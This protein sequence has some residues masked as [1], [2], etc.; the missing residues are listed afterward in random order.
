[1]PKISKTA[2]VG[3]GMLLEVIFLALVVLVL[4]NAM[5]YAALMEGLKL[6]EEF[7]FMRFV[8][9]I[10]PEITLVSTI[11][12]MISIFMKARGEGRN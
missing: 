12:I 7:A 6:P 11:L 1:M 5:F 4:R 10:T 8:L 3:L 2:L 9:R